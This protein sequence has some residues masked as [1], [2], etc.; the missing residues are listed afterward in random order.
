MGLFLTSLIF[1]YTLVDISTTIFCKSE[2]RRFP[3]GIFYL[4]DFPRW[5]TNGKF[6]RGVPPKSSNPDPA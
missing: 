3:H 2:L 6:G 1:A 5:E 4:Y